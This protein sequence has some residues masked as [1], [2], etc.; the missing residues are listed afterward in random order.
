MCFPHHGNGL[1]NQNNRRVSLHSKIIDLYSAGASRSS[2]AF[3][4]VSDLISV[5]LSV[6]LSQFITMF[7][8]WYLHNAHQI[9]ILWHS[10][11]MRS[12]RWK[13]WTSRSHETFE[14][15]LM[16]TRWPMPI[17]RIRFIFGKIQTRMGRWV[18][19]NFFVKVQRSGLTGCWKLYEYLQ[20]V[21]TDINSLDS[22]APVIIIQYINHIYII[23]IIRC[24][25]KIFQSRA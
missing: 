24:R 20:E 3:D 23:Y 17:W 21:A 15:Y 8:T 7:L 18:T 1:T 4:C 9:F 5:C 12:F 2:I 6:L 10:W 11:G 14:I 16:S 25:A 19:H 22:A 13:S